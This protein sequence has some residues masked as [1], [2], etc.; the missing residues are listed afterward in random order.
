MQHNHSILFKFSEIVGIL[1]IEKGCANDFITKCWSP[2]LKSET[3]AYVILRAIIS[4]LQGG[5]CIH[6]LSRY[7]YNNNDHI[8][9][10]ICGLNY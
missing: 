8:Y 4:H 9:T 1:Y 10:Y 3:E 7:T 5:H 2:K 6:V